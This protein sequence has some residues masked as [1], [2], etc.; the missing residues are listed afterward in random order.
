MKNILTLE[1]RDFP[2]LLSAIPDPP[3]RLYYRGDISILNAPRTVAFVGSRK[4]TDYG[5]SV[6]RDALP[7]L[8][9][10][11]SVSVSGLAIGID[12]IVHQETLNAGGRTIAVL[13][14][15]VDAHEVYPRRHQQ[16]SED[17]ISH[18]GLLLSEFEPGSPTYPGNFPQRNRIIA[19]L[20]QATVIVQAAHGSGSLITAGLALEYNRE[21]FAVPGSIYTEQAG[22]TNWLISE[23]ARPFLSAEQF[24][25]AMHWSPKPTTQATLPLYSPDEQHIVHA[26]THEPLTMNQLSAIVQLPLP[27]IMQ[28]LTQ[29]QIHKTVIRQSNGSFRITRPVSR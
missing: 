28:L 19:A 24:C 4:C 8:V 3:A 17:I 14:S 6:V 2:L 9:A 22:G 23:G 26:L 29:L 5:R 15:S 27:Y 10:V 13:G 7:T 1:A 16:L 21:V 25:A 11:D 12:G 18:G 20:A